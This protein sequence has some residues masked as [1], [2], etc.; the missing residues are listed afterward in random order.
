MSGAQTAAAATGPEPAALKGAKIC[1]RSWWALAWQ[2]EALTVGVC[3]GVV[4]H[5]FADWCFLTG[6]TTPFFKGKK[7]NF[8]K[9][10]F[11]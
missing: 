11:P 3:P 8:S 6:M 10:R 5:A 9:C 7:G 1:P 4:L 2:Q